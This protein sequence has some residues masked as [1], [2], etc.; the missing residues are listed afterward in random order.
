MLANAEKLNLIR[1]AVAEGLI[2]TPGGFRKKS[3][4]HLVRPGQ[5]VVKRGGISRVMNAAT[6]QLNPVALQ[7]LAVR[8]PDDQT[9]GW[10]TW[11][12]WSNQTGTPISSFATTWVVPPPPAEAASQLLYLFNGL[13]NPAG[14]EILQPV[15]QWGNSGAGG[16]PFWG[17]ASWHVDS[18]NH[19]FCTPLVPVNPGDSLTGVMTLTGSF[20][21]GTHNYR[22][23]F[24]GIDGTALLALGTPELT[25][26]EQTL[27]AYGM[28]DANQYPAAASTR[29]TQIDLQTGGAPAPLN[30]APNTMQNPLYGEHT[31]IVSYATPGGEVDLFY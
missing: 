5:A 1:N 25:D 2:S 17:V 11:A 13:Q 9:G 29:M 20:D 26:A 6:G 28:T 19:A 21:D 18:K 31:T 7:D 15:L 16:G 27:E 8:N 3:F 22:C 10:V 24:L 4:V 30:W 12:S 14:T 23:E